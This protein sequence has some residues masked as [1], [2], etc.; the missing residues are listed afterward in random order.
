MTPPLS[1]CMV[2]TFYPPYHFGGEAAFL[3][4]LCN[5]L[6]ERGHSVTVVHCVDA[7]QTLTKAGPRGAY[8][9]HP[10]VTVVPL[11][12]R[13]GPLSP[14]LS[15]LTGQP[16]L[17]ARPL[18]AIFRQNSFD[19]THY[20]LSTLMGPGA[21]S[22]GQ[23]IKL[24]TL[25]DH[26]F[27]CPMYDLWRYNG[28]VCEKPQCLR[29]TLSNRRPPQLW[30][31]TGLLKRQLPEIDLVLSPSRSAI[32]QHR[33]RG[34]A[35]PMR[36]L[37]HFLPASATALSRIGTRD[38]AVPNPR[39]YFLF[40]GRLVKVKGVQTL[41]ETFRNY[42]RADLLIAGDGDYE[43]ELRRQAEGLEHVRFLG[44][45]RPEDL[46]DL[47]AC[48]V[49]V[50]VPSLVYETFGLVAL[51]AFARRSPVI[52]RDQ[53]AVPELIRES[54]GGL[55]YRDEVELLQ[56]MEALRSDP[57]LRRRLGENAHRGFVERWSQEAHFQAYFEA[58]EEAR[59]L[60]RAAER[61]AA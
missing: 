30:R 29:C 25:H 53:G 20:H 15:Y 36:Y 49:A 45:V 13:L 31:Y 17:K 51:E 56:A 18:A 41:I 4:A 1:F 42:D 10:N 50:L 47:Y 9:H 2:T 5:G 58:I 22:Y 46:H 55:T 44:R 27:V 59:D 54:S 26:W 23:G 39:Q 16:G 61:A 37:P 43:T 33:R 3:H 19:V 34:F 12:S 35:A 8:P 60:R 38:Q 52:A 24:Y 48:A 6:A 28:E 57:G 14:A 40:V 7:Y 32:E 11:H 21:F